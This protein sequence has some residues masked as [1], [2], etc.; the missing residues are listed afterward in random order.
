LTASLGGYN[1]SGAHGHRRG[2]MYIGIGGVVLL[3]VVLWL[4]FGR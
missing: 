1:R 2:L 3:I 4:L